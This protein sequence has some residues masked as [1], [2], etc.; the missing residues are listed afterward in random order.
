MTLEAKYKLQLES[1][2]APSWMK[3]PGFAML[4]KGYL[5]KGETPRQMYWRIS[6]A[7]AK[8]LK[9]PEYAEKFFNLFWNNILCPA[10]PVASNLGTERG[11]PI[12]CYGQYVPDSIKG[13]AHTLAEAKTLAKHGGGLGGYI[14]DVRGSG[15][16]IG[17]V[18]KDGN[19]VQFGA[20][21]ITSGDYH[22]SNGFSEG[23][24]P[25]VKEFD[26]MTYATSQG[27][28]RRGAYAMYVDITHP[29]I[30]KFLHM[31]KKKPDH[32]EICDKM[33]HGVVIPDSFMERI[34][35]GD[36]EA[37]E[38][39]TE[40]LKL[41]MEEG[42]PYI[43]YIDNAN[44]VLPESYV[45]HNLKVRAPQLCTEIFL[46]SNERYTYVC[47]LSSLNA[48]TF[49]KWEAYQA[50]FWS[51]VFLDGV[52]E[53]YIQKIKLKMEEDPM[54][55]YQWQRSY[56]FAVESR[57]LGLGVLGWHSLLQSKMIP[58]DSFES[59]MMNS[60]IFKYIQDE[61]E[62]ATMFLA[63][64]YGEPL[65][66]KGLG[67]RN[68]HLGAVAPTRSNSLIAGGW[69]KGIEPEDGVTYIENAA[70]GSYDIRNPFFE[71]ILN[72]YEKNTSEVWS[73]IVE[74][75]GSVQH[76]TFLSDIEKE[77][78]L[79]AYEINQFAILKQAAQ[80]QAFIDQGQSINLFFPV[81]AS[82]EYIMQVHLAA[83]KMGLKSLYYC[84]SKSVAK[85]DIGSRE[86]KREYTECASCE[87]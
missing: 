24:M 53:D 69:S 7:A 40:V 46:A 51:I 26:S 74:N 39:Y 82:P 76:L 10:S 66:C 31:R 81:G 28:T 73:T 63:K 84:K 11:L 72:L 3:L 45:K 35:N 15:S 79:T 23:I 14:G 67:R 34:Y 70:K 1:G 57:A 55:A 64:E 49:D 58:F 12:S 78:F 29:D 9:H 8:A 25:F 33:H 86:Y 52:M 60:R 42:E 83:H 87:G 68:T 22:P 27:S 71:Q 19:P 38:L 2:E 59:M 6:N 32:M 30:H 17:L 47:C 13:I 41:R 54:Y 61:S 80:R 62:A 56:N 37:Q 77:V 50:P 21:D 44:K 18:D 48:M 85:G 43:C 16:P 20:V 4:Q 65:L 75:H 36:K 5:L